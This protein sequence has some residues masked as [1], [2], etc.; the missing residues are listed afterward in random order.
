M[1]HI[2]RATIDIIGWIFVV[3]GIVGIFLPFLQGILFVI[4]GFYLLSLHSKWAH[5]QLEK[6]TKRF[7]K[8]GSRIHSFDHRVRKFLRVDPL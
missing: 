5:S 7:P 8:A 6:I 1:K 2:K 4:V 3:I